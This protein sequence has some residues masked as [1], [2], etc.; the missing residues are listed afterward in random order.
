[1]TPILILAAG[2]SSRMRG[3]DKLLE[4]VDG[5]PLIRRQ[6]QAALETGE[7]VYV[8]VPALDHPRCAAIEDL[9]IA[10][11]DV[12]TANQGMS[13]SLKTGIHALPASP[14][15]MVF[16]AD[17]VG[18]NADDLKRMLHFKHAPSTL[19]LRGADQV[20]KH[21]H[22]IIFDASLRPDFE[23]LSGD[24]GGAE[25]IKANRLQLELVT[26]PDDHATLDLDTPEDWAAFRA[27]L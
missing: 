6:V 7:S 20:G 16:L 22:P 4:V 17:L 10:L 19:I 14:R 11:I 15:F 13:E 2:R 21:G 5:T 8:A 1:M 23:L 3:A 12:P 27:K 18:L 25:I 26:L 24:S 9:G